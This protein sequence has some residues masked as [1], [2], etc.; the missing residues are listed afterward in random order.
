LYSVP[1]R[2]GLQRMDR[3]VT[4]CRLPYSQP[5]STEQTKVTSSLDTTSML[6]ITTLVSIRIIYLYK[7]S[8][9]RAFATR[10]NNEPVKE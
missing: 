6:S 8:S 4:T 9:T 1:E 5:W 7:E 3:A 10:T 2:G